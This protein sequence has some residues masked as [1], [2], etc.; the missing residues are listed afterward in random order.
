MICS[1]SHIAGGSNAGVR[2]E[3]RAGKRGRVASDQRSR[4]ITRR[5]D[6]AHGHRLPRCGLLGN[7]WTIPGHELKFVVETVQGASR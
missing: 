3:R 5:L 4:G 2:S 1:F 7:H 6:D